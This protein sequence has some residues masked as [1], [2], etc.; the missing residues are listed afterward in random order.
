MS[1]EEICRM[2]NIAFLETNPEQIV[3]L[4]E[5][6]SLEARGKFSDLS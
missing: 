3:Q 2:D 5:L 6:H 4:T 1:A